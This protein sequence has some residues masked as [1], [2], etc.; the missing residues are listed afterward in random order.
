MSNSHKKTDES[1]LRIMQFGPRM[2]A[3]TLVWFTKTTKLIQRSGPPFVFSGKNHDE[4]NDVVLMPR[5]QNWTISS[6]LPQS[7]THFAHSSSIALPQTPSSNT[8]IFSFVSIYHSWL[9]QL[10]T[11][12]WSDSDSMNALAK[13]DVALVTIFISALKLDSISSICNDIRT[14]RRGEESMKL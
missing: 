14:K 3:C 8:V 11:D 9:L 2:V 5:V 1:G 4:W 6:L 13:Y 12:S 10:N 7:T